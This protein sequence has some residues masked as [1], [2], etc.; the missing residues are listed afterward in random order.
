[1][2]VDP[3]AV[4]EAAYRL[5]VD[6][7]A[8]LQT[9][10]E[11]IGP[12]LQDG[13]GVA[14]S[15]ADGTSMVPA[16]ARVLAL[17]GLELTPALVSSLEYMYAFTARSHS[18]A[19]RFLTKG[20]LTSIQR[21]L[22]EQFAEVGPTLQSFGISDAVLLLCGDA[23]GRMCTL[24]APRARRAALPRHRRHL[25]ELLSAHVAAGTRLRAHRL[26]SAL[27]GA[28]VEAVLTPDGRVLDARNAAQ[29]QHGR[30]L[31]REAVAR[32]EQARGALRRRDPV[33]A[34]SL[35]QALVGGRWSLVDVFDRDGKRFVVARH[36]EPPVARR[37]A[38]TAREAQVVELVARNHPPKLIV[39]QL[40]LTRES[41]ATHLRRALAKLGLRHRAELS[42]LFL[43]SRGEL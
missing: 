15:L 37:L 3:L 22:G 4:V 27:E 13:L 11:L 16:P 35:W 43:A 30:A 10:A 33:A 18:I 28:A 32:S 29:S 9:L 23:F 31:L 20:A 39:Y 1:M 42:A 12:L 14:A 19:R 24:A 38:L 2:R 40:G 41:V 36:N 7:Q 5:D 34:L 8:W 25:L 6:D 17:G 26:A 21:C